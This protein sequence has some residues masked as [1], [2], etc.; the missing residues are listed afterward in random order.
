MNQKTAI[1][2][3]L[4]HACCALGNWCQL[5]PWNGTKDCEE[6]VFNN[7]LDKAIK[8]VSTIDLD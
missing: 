7:V 8:I 2:I 3:L 6:T 4:A 5:C 1:D